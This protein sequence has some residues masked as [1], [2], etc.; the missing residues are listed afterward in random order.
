MQIK[1]LNLKKKNRGISAVNYIKMREKNIM[2]CLI[3][4][5][6]TVNKEFWKTVK[7]FLY[8]KVTAFPKISLAEKVEIISDESKFANSFSN[9]FEKTTR[10]LGIKAK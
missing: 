4:K 6:V 8:H 7:Q 3:K 1:I 5:N 2:K 9:F 10:S